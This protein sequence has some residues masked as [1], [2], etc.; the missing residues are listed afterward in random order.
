MRTIA[1]AIGAGL[2]VPVRSLSETEAAAHFDWMA[3]F[4]AIDNQWALEARADRLRPVA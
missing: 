2:G 1:E 3:R 4:V